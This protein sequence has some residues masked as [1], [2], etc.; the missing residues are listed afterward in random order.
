[1]GEG[2]GRVDYNTVGNK[3]FFPQPPVEPSLVGRVLDRAS[4]TIPSARGRGLVSQSSYRTSHPAPSPCFSLS[5]TWPVLTLCFNPENAEGLEQQNHGRIH[6]SS[7]QLKVT[8]PLQRT[9]CPGTV[10]RQ[11]RVLTK[12]QYFITSSAQIFHYKP[13][14]VL[15][16]ESVGALGACSRGSCQRRC[17]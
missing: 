16:R 10:W 12:N 13:G 4:T 6:F 9:R 15:R 2:K 1:M 8:E 17:L 11:R 5:V 7:V 14:L 3:R